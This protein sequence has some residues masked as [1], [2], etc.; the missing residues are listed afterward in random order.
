M[1]QYRSSTSTPT[2]SDIPSEQGDWTIDHFAAQL[3]VLEAS[4]LKCKEL[5]T[6]REYYKI[7]VGPSESRASSPSPLNKS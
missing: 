1:G 3:E 5:L 7:S 2:R 4:C 6:F